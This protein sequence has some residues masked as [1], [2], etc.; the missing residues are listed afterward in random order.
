MRKQAALNVLMKDGTGRR[1][2]GDRAEALID[3]GQ[4]KRYISNTIYQALKLGIEVEDFGT[5]D[6]DGVLK[7]KVRDARERSQ[8]RKK[9][10]DESD[11][12]KEEQEADREDQ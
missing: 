6:D 1:V 7:A 4:A 10:R 5:R 3:S 2:P 9:K 8:K 11:R 12:R